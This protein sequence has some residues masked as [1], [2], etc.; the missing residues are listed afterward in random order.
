MVQQLNEIRQL[1]Q[2]KIFGHTSI[3]HFNICSQ[4]IFNRLNKCHTAAIGV[5]HLKCNKASCGNQ[6]YQYHSCNDRHC[7]NCGGLK[8]EQW[9]QDRMCEL[10]PT[11]YYHIVFTLPQELRSLVM[12]NRTALFNLLFEAAHY[13]INTLSAD[14]KWLGAKPGIVSILHTNGQDLSFH[15]HIHCIVSGG[16]IRPSPVGEG[17]GVRWVK[18]K[19]ANGAY[20]YPKDAMQKIYKAYFIKRLRKLMEQQKLKIEDAAALEKTI[21][22]LT[23]VRW[24]VHANAPFGGP[25]QILEYLGRYTH[26][27]AITAHRI[28]EITAT[29]ITFTYKDY[30]D[31]KK[32]KQMKLSHAEFV[33]R[34]EQHLLPKRFVK[35][36]HGGYLA[37]NG[38]NKRV[39]AIHEQLKLPKPMPKVIIPF[40]LQ[41]LQRTGTDYSVCPK[42]REGKMEITASYLN[43]NGTL[44]NIKDL[45][46]IKNKASPIKSRI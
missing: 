23:T 26:K 25:A 31:G 12:G 3:K 32:Q 8:K 27:T 40:S 15:P 39:A 42:C 46:K 11:T 35:I 20:L 37:H 17:L 9:L 10:L 30:A 41:M 33:R 13:T 38:K 14:I 24:N 44:I 4:A 45:Q 22:Q 34:F 29:E 43:H 2:Q 28:T 6:L 1:L 21:S 5:H 7:P 18:E 36:R 19:R 16:G